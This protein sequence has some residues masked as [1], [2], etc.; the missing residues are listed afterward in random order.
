MAYKLKQKYL[1]VDHLSTR[2]RETY[3]TR[4]VTEETNT[5]LKPHAHVRLR[6]ITVKDVIALLLHKT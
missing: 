6:L 3:G 2:A 1:S 4:C 5:L